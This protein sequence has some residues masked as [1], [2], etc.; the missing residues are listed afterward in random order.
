MQRHFFLGHLL[1]TF[2]ISVVQALQV[3]WLHKLLEGGHCLASLQG[4]LRSGTVQQAPG[5]CDSRHPGLSSTMQCSN[6]PIV[7]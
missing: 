5:A 6:M 7:V 2:N 1:A 3:S 4:L